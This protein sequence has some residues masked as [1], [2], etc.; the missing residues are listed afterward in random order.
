MDGLR[1]GEYVSIE[2][3]RANL[4]VKAVAAVQFRC[5]AA[6]LPRAACHE[7]G[8]L[9]K[10]WLRF[11]YLGTN[12]TA[13]C[14]EVMPPSLL[15]CHVHGI[16]WCLANSDTLETCGLHRAAA[17]YAGNRGTPWYLGGPQSG[18]PYSLPLCIPDN[19]QCS[20]YCWRI[21]SGSQAP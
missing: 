13:F 12:I 18:Q 17:K 4:R 10:Q 16:V 15:S 7:T 9:S 11:N 1:S 19:M 5:D 8:R 2:T 14:R 3:C 21:A 6:R 20:N